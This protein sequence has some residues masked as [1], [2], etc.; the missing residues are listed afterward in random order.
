MKFPASLSTFLHVA[1]L[2]WGL[3]S[4]SGPKPL[5]VADVEALPI[6]IV[7][8]E[9]VSRAVQGE[10]KADVADKPA[11]KPSQ[12]PQKNPD[13]QNI[14]DAEVDAKTQRI[15]EPTP[16]PDNSQRADSAPKAEKPKPAPQ[17]KPEPVAQPV[18]ESTPEKTTELAALDQP[19]QP[20]PDQTPIETPAPAETGEQFAKL[21]DNVPVPQPKPQ[22]PKPASAETRER[23]EQKEKPRE[24]T[25]ATSNQ[26]SKSAT[27]EIAALLNKEKPA[28]S[29][30]KRSSERAALGTK[31]PGTGGK[32]SQSEMDA[33]RGQLATCWSIPVGVQ[34][35][36]DLRASVRFYL[37][38]NGKLTGQPEITTSSG[39]RQFDESA[40]R[41][42]LKCDRDGLNVPSGKHDIWNTVVVNF[43]PSQM[44]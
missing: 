43:D 25:T 17:V 34:D 1:I 44:F 35:G 12:K 28:D 24:E 20:I 21:P 37:D 40:R 10:K 27:D 36:Q 3:L 14:G 15:A 2:S 42:I 6:D 38:P 19:R 22:P 30:A 16:K 13:A 4:L 18:K 32:L 41:A 26:E 11:P 5:A 9:E 8:I 31:K 39:N 29:G 7:P 23:K 33:L